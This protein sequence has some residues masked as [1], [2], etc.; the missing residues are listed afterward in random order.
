MER[1]TKMSQL[2]ESSMKTWTTI[3]DKIKEQAVIEAKSSIKIKRVLED[4]LDLSGNY[5]NN[6]TITTQTYL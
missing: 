1:L 2:K 3:R 6:I 4:K 5:H